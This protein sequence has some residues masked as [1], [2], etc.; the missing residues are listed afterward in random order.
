MDFTNI[1]QQLKAERDK[2]S[3]AIV[4]LQAI[5]SGSPAPRRR[6]RPPKNSIEGNSEQPGKQK[7]AKRTKEQRE[8]QAE[9]MRQYWA[10]RK[11]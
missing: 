9:R 5:G 3:A 2:I 4:S 7:R 10:N 1:L 8:A 11:A 6:G